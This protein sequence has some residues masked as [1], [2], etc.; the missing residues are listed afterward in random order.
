MVECCAGLTSEEW[1]QHPCMVHAMI[2]VAFFLGLP[3]AILPFTKSP[4]SFPIATEVSVHS[5]VD[6]LGGTRYVWS[7]HCSYSVGP[8][9][10]ALELPTR[11]LDS[12]QW[13]EVLPADVLYTEDLKLAFQVC[14]TTISERGLGEGERRN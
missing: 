3:G 10:W 2:G 5:E 8:Q 12:T 13:S 14:G 1:I 4:R 11:V 7:W 6:I 9:A